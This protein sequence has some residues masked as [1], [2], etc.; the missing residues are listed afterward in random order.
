VL[1]TNTPLTPE[2][3]PAD[4]TNTFPEEVED[5]PLTIVT[6][7]PEAE[8]ENPADRKIIPPTPLFPD[9]TLI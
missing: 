8:E 3:A 9:P 1:K 2:V 7:P 4:V 5:F 6:A